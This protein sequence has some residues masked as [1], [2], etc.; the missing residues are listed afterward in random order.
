MISMKVYLRPS[1]VEGIPGLGDLILVETQFSA[2]P[3]SAFVGAGTAAPE[4]VVDLNNLY[5]IDRTTLRIAGGEKSLLR[6]YRG[7]T[8]STLLHYRRFPASDGNV[9]VAEPVKGFFA[10]V[11]LDGR[12]DEEDFAEFR[13]QYRSLP[14]DVAYNPDFNF[15]ADPAGKVDAQ[16][17]A[18]FAKEYGRTGVQ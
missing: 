3:V 9:T 6:I 18:R 14:D 8:L 2:Y 4:G 12:V 15:L 17:F 10:D 5:G 1:D 13:K 7:G 11:N 16:D